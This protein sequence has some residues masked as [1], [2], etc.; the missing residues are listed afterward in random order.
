MKTFR[1][2]V[3]S[4]MFL[5]LISA[6]ASKEDV[7]QEVVK[8]Y[9]LKE[10]PDEKSY[11][12][13]EFSKL[14]TAYSVVDNDSTYKAMKERLEAFEYR[15]L[16]WSLSDSKSEIHNSIKDSVEQYERTYRPTPIGWQIEHEFKA[17]VGLGTWGVFKGQFVLNWG[18]DSVCYATINS[19]T[20]N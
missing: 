3:Y 16:F 13:G 6:C 17:N 11:T 14:D 7:A 9:I 8:K 18:L 5:C 12:P 1:F 4:F 15:H 10:L 20:Y 19:K 2:F